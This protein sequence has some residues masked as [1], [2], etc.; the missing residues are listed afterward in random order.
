MCIETEISRER[1]KEST[2]AVR[3]RPN[4]TICRAGRQA[5]DSGELMV[6]FLPESEALRAGR[7]NDV[8]L[9]QGLASPEGANVS[10]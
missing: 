3:R 9:V 8:V 1:V 2:R 6:S 5:G 4:P 7:G 10:V